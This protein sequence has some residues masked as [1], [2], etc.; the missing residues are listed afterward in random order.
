MKIEIPLIGAKR[1]LV[2][3]VRHN[4]TEYLHRKALDL[5]SDTTLT[6]SHME[7]ILSQLEYTLPSQKDRLIFECY[8]ISHTDGRFTVASRSVL[9]NGKSETSLYRKYQIK[10]IPDGKIDDFASMREVMRRRYVE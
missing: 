10:D 5:L 1:E 4:A 9:V 3:F 7:S 6:R 8:D 2:N